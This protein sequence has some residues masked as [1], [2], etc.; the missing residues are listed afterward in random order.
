MSLLKTI[1]VIAPG[2]TPRGPADRVKTDR[3]DAELLAR[4]LLAGSL[5]RHGRPFEL[6][7]Y[8][9]G[10]HGI[11]LGVRPYDPVKLHPW[12]IECRRWLFEHGFGDD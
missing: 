3:K 5:D 1:E 9:K 4:L 10:P 12:T 11:G 6:H 7:V 8:E 2:K